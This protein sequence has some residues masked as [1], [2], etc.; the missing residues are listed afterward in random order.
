MKQIKVL[1]TTVFTLLTFTVL[2]AETINI[3][4]PEVPEV[5]KVEAIVPTVN[6]ISN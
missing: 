5:P 4:I 1:K 3:K 2:N 6:V